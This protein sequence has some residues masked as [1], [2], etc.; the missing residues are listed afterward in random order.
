[1]YKVVLIDDEK[2]A[3]ISTE[4]S[5]D[6]ESNG[7]RVHNTFCNPHE[8]I[9]TLKT[10]RID[11]AF[12]DLRMPEISGFDIIKTCKEANINTCFVIVTGYS[13][14][15]YA[16]KAIKLDVVDYCVKPIQKEDTEYLLSKLSSTILKKRLVTD[17]RYVNE[18][19]K[20]DDPS[21]L[22]SFLT[23]DINR[24]HYWVVGICS[25]ANVAD[26]VVKPHGITQFHLMI[27]QHTAI[28][29][30]GDDSDLSDEINEE[31]S[32]VHSGA[33]L[34]SSIINHIKLIP[35]TVR[36]VVSKLETT[37]INQDV[38]IS[39]FDINDSLDINESFLSLMDYVNEHY[40]QDLSLQSLSK[41]YNINYTYC[42][43]LFKKVTGNNFT[44]Y[45]T[46]LRLK[47]ACELL[48]KSDKSVTDIAYQ[49]GYNNYH[50]FAKVFK[51]NVGITP[52]MHRQRATKDGM[53][54]E[55]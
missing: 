52:I 46:N 36:F 35:S 38:E 3:L 1:M 39:T 24:K 37:Y 18:L 54:Y 15:Q 26:V 55:L 43:E 34:I 14:F 41:N 13:D 29:V 27:D 42:S 11:I 9:N 16:Q 8:A 23:L 50:Y 4:H 20:A 6:W 31:Y 12:V 10:E 2:M 7:F 25:S 17:I 51:Q 48:V 22:L 53:S 33:V 47:K 32:S 21:D 19:S 5:F 49:V 44:T 40:D 30:Y 45:F 28:A